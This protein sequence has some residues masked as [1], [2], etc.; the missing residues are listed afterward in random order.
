VWGVVGGAMRPGP[1][2]MTGM[3]VVVLVIVLVL[4][5]LILV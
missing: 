4:R 5:L 1:Y 3:I 2:G